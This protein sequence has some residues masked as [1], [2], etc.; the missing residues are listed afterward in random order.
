MI[1]H[2]SKVRLGH[3]AF[4][5]TGSTLPPVPTLEMKSPTPEVEGLPI[6]TADSAYDVFSKKPD[7][8]GSFK[9]WT[10]SE[11]ERNLLPRARRELADAEEI[12]RAR[13]E[14]LADFT[15]PENLQELQYDAYHIINTDKNWAVHAHAIQLVQ[16]PLARAAGRD[17]WNIASHIRG[18]PPEA[19]N[20][21]RIEVVTKS[22]SSVEQSK[23][24]GGDRSGVDIINC[25]HELAAT[26]AQT[27]LTQIQNGKSVEDAMNEMIAEGRRYNPEIKA[28]NRVGF[29]KL[30]DAL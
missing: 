11:L 8:Q 19:F 16:D 7:C 6:A 29:S 15:K 27:L 25:S 10:T 20:V 22:A 12:A 14:H 26:L 24:G 30:P 13:T 28:L 1:T 23:R 4:P 21:Y 18:D 2:L 5:S 3:D 9:G 17:E